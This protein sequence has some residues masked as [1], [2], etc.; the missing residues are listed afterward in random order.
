M[1][2]TTAGPKPLT[3]AWL[4]VAALTTTLLLWASAFV[5]IRHLGHDVTPGAL[6][7]GRLLVAALVLG[8]FVLRKRVRTWPRATD[9]PLLLCCGATWFGIYNLALNDAERRIDAGTAALLVQIGPLL[10]AL[11]ATVF[12]GERMHRWLAIGMGVGFTGVLLI[13]QGTSAGGSG[14][15]VGVALA[16]VAALT[17]AIGVL[18][19]KPL[20]R[21]LPPLEVTF[22]ACLIGAVVCL[23]WTGDLVDTVHH[24]STP[25]L[26]WIGYLGAFPTALAFTTWAYA[27]ARTDA[28]KTALTTFLVPLIATLLAW[29]LLDEVPPGLA[30]VG[31]ALCIL[32]VLL[33]RRRPRAPQPPVPG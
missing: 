14:D 31:G 33:T 1:V 3:R 10:V 27:L 30:F 25:D 16:V 13:G 19:Q 18:T 7:L 32:G 21:R 2:T 24:G 5:A 12:L 15:L 22:L 6:S 28:S 17:Y 29:L 26:L 9:W 23:P 20:L 4:P 11:L 8:G